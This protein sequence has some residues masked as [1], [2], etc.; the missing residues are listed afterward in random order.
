MADAPKTE[1]FRAREIVVNTG[2]DGALIERDRNGNKMLRGEAILKD[3][4]RLEILAF[5][6]PKGSHR[7]TPPIATYLAEAV[8]EH[9]NAGMPP[10]EFVLR[11]RKMPEAWNPRTGKPYP[12]RYVVESFA[13]TPLDRLP[14]KPKPRDDDVR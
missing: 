2:E 12:I 14:R 5:D 1:I 8:F 6:K 9:R 13:T 7:F 3:G 4:S 11:A 10:T